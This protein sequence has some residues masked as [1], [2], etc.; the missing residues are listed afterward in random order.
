MDADLK[1]NKPTTAFFRTARLRGVADVGAGL[2]AH[3]VRRTVVLVVVGRH[4]RGRLVLAM[5]QEGLLGTPL[6]ED[7]EL[8]RLPLLFHDLG[9]SINASFTIY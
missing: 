7:D 1:V 3:R 9:S 2:A 6:E 8:R 4:G 5:A